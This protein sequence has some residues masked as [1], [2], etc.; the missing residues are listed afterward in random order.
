[1]HSKQLIVMCVGGPNQ[2][3]DYH[4]EEGEELFYQLKG[5]MCVKIVENGK[6]KDVVIKE[7]EFFILPAKIPHSPQR[8]A[9]SI[10]LVVER[11][12]LIS[13]QDGVRWYIPNTVNTLYQNWVRLFFSS[14][15]DSK[16]NM[17]F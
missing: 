3:E 2:R 5:D 4:M 10:G 14:N 16:K 8:S 11:R 12:R 15:L 9:N 17:F 13:E 1:M 7:G 6:H